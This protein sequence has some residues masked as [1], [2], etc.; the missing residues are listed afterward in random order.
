MTSLP[1]HEIYAIRYA[2]RDAWRRDHFIGGDPHELP[3]A[4]DYFVWVIIGPT[5]PIVLDLGF[6][7]EMAKQRKREFLRCPIDGLKLVG[8]DPREVKDVI[9]SHMHYDHVGN[10]DKLPNARF[11][12]QAREMAFATGK[13]MRYA[14]PGHSYHVEDV[15][16]MVRL[17]FKGR[18]E[19]HEGMVEV[20]PGITLHP[21]P[22]H[23]DG[24]QVARVHTRRGWVVLA[25]DAT[26]YYENFLKNRPFATAFHIGEMLDA[27]RTLERLAPSARHIIPGHDPHVMQEYEPPKPELAGAVVRLD[28]APTGPAPSFPAPAGH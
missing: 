8:V 6:T 26:H 3:M 7:A 5:G 25:S 1:E 15:V 10:F 24:L 16:G 28:L 11:H 23:A 17:N 9:V 2:R 27:Y 14:K 19:M 20:A 22:G 12:L 18:V 4:M 21:A 13:Y